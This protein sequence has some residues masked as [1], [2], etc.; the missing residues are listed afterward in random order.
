MFLYANCTAIFSL[1]TCSIIMYSM[2][3]LDL[4]VSLLL[5]FHKYDH[6][7]RD[8][9]YITYKRG[10][11]EW[12]RTKSSHHQR[13]EESWSWKKL[14]EKKRATHKE[15][16][17]FCVSSAKHW[18]EKERIFINIFDL[19]SFWMGI[20]ACTHKNRNIYSFFFAY[21][22]EYL[23]IGFLQVN[24]QSWE[25][26]TKQTKHAFIQQTFDLRCKFFT[27][28]FT[29]FH[30]SF[31]FVHSSHSQIR[32]FC[33]SKEEEVDTRKII[34]NRPSKNHHHHH[35]EWVNKAWEYFEYHHNLSIKWN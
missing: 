27:S 9:E 15:R 30:F 23:L 4:V 21:R 10:R 19:Y 12:R 31:C 34:S 33:C 8:N 7:D 17:F 20:E 18:N 14:V 25:D 2:T 32:R 3:R 11:G 13:R 28:F 26:W 1:K 22:L 29:S 5:D 6:A 24:M 35:R 16:G